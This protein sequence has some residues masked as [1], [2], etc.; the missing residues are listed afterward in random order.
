MAVWK[1]ESID[2][3]CVTVGD[4]PTAPV[5]VAKRIADEL[6][7]HWMNEWRKRI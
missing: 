6:T 7:E 4:P 5:S 1:P 3:N 2:F